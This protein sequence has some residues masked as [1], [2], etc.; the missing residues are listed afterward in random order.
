MDEHLFHLFGQHVSQ[1]KVFVHLH[2][3]DIKSPARHLAHE[4]K[5][6]A[7]VLHQ[8]VAQQ[9]L[10]PQQLLVPVVFLRQPRIC[11]LI[12]PP[13]RITQETQSLAVQVPGRKPL[14]FLTPF[15]Q[16]KFHIGPQP[17]QLRHRL[18]L[19]SLQMRE[20]AMPP[21][22]EHHSNPMFPPIVVYHVKHSTVTS[23]IKG[24][25]YIRKQYKYIHNIYTL[26]TPQKRLAHFTKVAIYPIAS[27]TNRQ[28]DKPSDRF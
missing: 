6:T 25:R 2:L 8:L 24:V 20:K 17:P 23:A 26:F 16:T 12:F 11:P 14:Y 9:R 13:K 19:V 4:I 18:Q 21:H 1:I 15:V 7:F 3:Y 22:I 10:G 5:E 28:K 27:K